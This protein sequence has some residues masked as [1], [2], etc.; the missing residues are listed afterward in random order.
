[1]PITVACPACASTLKC[2]NSAASRRIKCPKCSASVTVPDEADELVPVATLSTPLAGRQ[3]RPQVVADERR[4]CSF[5]GEHIQAS[6]RKCPHCGETLDAAVRAAEE[7][8]RAS[9]RREPARGGDMHTTVIVNGGERSFP[10]FL[11]LV[12]TVG[13]CGLWFPIWLTHY[14]F[15][16]R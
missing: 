10:H 7:D 6:A 13:T 12:L 4:P 11:H 2:P 3:S 16:S 9:R 1:M 8:R 5:C 15:C 14:I